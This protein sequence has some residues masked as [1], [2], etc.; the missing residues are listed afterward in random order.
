MK[1]SCGKGQFLVLY[2]CPHSFAFYL[3]CHPLKLYHKSS[4]LR[5]ASCLFRDERRA[6]GKKGNLF[7]SPSK[8]KLNPWGAGGGGGR[9][10]G[11][12][13]VI[14]RGRC[15]CRLYKPWNTN[16]PTNPSSKFKRPPLNST[17]SN[18]MSYFSGPCFGIYR[19]YFRWI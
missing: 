19:R 12:R 10:G 3:L 8:V 9:G 7:L 13:S 14:M 15:I 2:K 1:L 11:E 17:L 18:L 6:K 16:T 5:S 4:N